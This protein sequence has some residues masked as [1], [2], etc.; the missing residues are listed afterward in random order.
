MYA[1]W[2]LRESGDVLIYS[3]KLCYFHLEV[4]LF[5]QL[6]NQKWL[7]IVLLVDLFNFFGSWIQDFGLQSY[8]SGDF[9][10]HQIF[11]CM[12]MRVTV[13]TLSHTQTY[14]ITY[15]HAKL[16]IIHVKLHLVPR[17]ATYK[18]FLRMEDNVMYAQTF[19]DVEAKSPVY[20]NICFYHL[21][22][23]MVQHESKTLQKLL[24]LGFQWYWFDIELFRLCLE[25]HFSK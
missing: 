21:L 7:G 23:Q 8:L 25:S 5:E 24:D 4:N 17:N 2:E 18:E 15:T 3:T 16:P 13:Q 10:F 1:Q 9:D 11:I 22:D 19:L 12:C 14:A 20:L 6:E